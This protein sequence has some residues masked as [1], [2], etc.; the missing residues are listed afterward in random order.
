[1]NEMLNISGRPKHLRYSGPDM[2]CFDSGD[3]VT[4][5]LNVT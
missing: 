1:M 4:W 2:R 3:V 5:D